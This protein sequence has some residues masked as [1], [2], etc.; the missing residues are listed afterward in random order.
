MIA[1]VKGVIASSLAIWTVFGFGASRAT[2][3]D[4][5]TPADDVIVSQPDPTPEP[6]PSTERPP[7]P[8]TP[9]GGVPVVGMPVEPPP[10]TPMERPQAPLPPPHPEPPPIPP[11][12]YSLELQ[13]RVAFPDE[14]SFDRA[15]SAFGY[16][17]VRVEPVTYLGVQVPLLEWLWIGGRFGMRGRNWTHP[18]RDAAV[19]AAGDLL[20]T[21][22]VRLALG[23]VVELGVLFGGGAGVVV[24]QLNGV[25]ADQVVGRFQVEAIAAFRVGPNFALGPRLGWGYFQ[26]EGMN[27]Y[28]HGLDI[29][30]PYF[31]LSLEARE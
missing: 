24:T 9:P 3:Q 8:L 10:P 12:Q 5:A 19:V 25:A 26:W 21:A 14:S 2:A 16:S 27:R 18:D 28:D 11:P 1:A 29:G 13:I 23:R 6:P 15:M 22:Q 20:V 30:G 17:G 31:G 7:G 4:A